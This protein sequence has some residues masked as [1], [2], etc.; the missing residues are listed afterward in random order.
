MEFNSGFTGLKV[1]L[2]NS[3]Y[4]QLN[5]PT[6]CSNFSSLLLVIWWCTDLQTLKSL[7]I[8]DWNIIAFQAFIMSCFG[9]WRMSFHVENVY[10]ELNHSFLV[11]DTLQSYTSSQQSYTEIVNW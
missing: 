9:Q 6:R 5:Q 7:Y 3:V 2:Q 8:F 10:R 4:I 1:K 11:P